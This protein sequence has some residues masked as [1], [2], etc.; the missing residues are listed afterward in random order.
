MESLKSFTMSE[1]KSYK[2]ELETRKINFF[3]IGCIVAL[4]LSWFC[5][6]L[7]ASVKEEKVIIQDEAEAAKVEEY[8]PPA[9][10]QQEQPQQQE[11]QQQANEDIILDMVDNSKQTSFDIGDIFNQEQET[12][13]VPEYDDSDEG[14]GPPPDDD[15]PPVQFAQKQ[16]E[17]PGG[18]DALQKFLKD[19]T[20]YP[21]AAKEARAQGTVMVQFVVERD[22]S[23]TDIKILSSVFPALDQEAI[24]VCKAMPKWIPGENNNK[25]VRVFYRMP[26]QFSLE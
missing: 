17:F 15:A 6:D 20:Q 22:G 4:S 2:A 14:D 24:R 11:E 18:P 1:K 16:P 9:T 26:F 21:Q 10:E 5:L 23:V 7:F 8:I 25:K 13:E 3:L 19:E 12:D